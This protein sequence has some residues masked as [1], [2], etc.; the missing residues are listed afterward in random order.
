MTTSVL[1]REDHVQRL[2]GTAYRSADRDSVLF[3]RDAAP[4]DASE[5]ARRILGE[6]SFSHLAF[7]MPMYR[8]V[9]DSQ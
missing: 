4:A 3:E 8:R 2:I 6:A 1:Y 5:A 7:G 9:R